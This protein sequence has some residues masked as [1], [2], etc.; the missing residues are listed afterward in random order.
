MAAR[1]RA[2]RD[3]IALLD[4]KDRM[5]LDLVPT[6]QRSL[7][8]VARLMEVSPGQLS[9]RLRALLRRIDHPFVHHLFHKSCLLHPALR[10]VGIEYYLLDMTL[11]AIAD[12]HQMSERET[13]ALVEQI[14]GY[15]KAMRFRI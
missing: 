11:R 8:E 4:L 7:R 6:G 12:K 1:L 13:R 3:R 10:Q 9:R 14:K 15:G 2:M 5:L